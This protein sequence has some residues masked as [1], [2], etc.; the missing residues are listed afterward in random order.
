MLKSQIAGLRCPQAFSPLYKC[1]RVPHKPLT[2]SPP[3]YRLI[4]S[5]QVSTAKGA[6]NEEKQSSGTML[7]PPPPDPAP[8]PL[9]R[10]NDRTQAGMSRERIRRKGPYR[11]PHPPWGDPGGSETTDDGGGGGDRVIGTLNRDC[12]PAG[13]WPA[14]VVGRGFI[15]PPFRSL[16]VRVHERG[17]VALRDET[18]APGALHRSTS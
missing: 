13:T 12:I 16:Q 6:K 7:P 14:G 17:A 10:R 18:A 4:L 2:R 15:P 3:P 11:I 9:E 1:T 5:L 8:S